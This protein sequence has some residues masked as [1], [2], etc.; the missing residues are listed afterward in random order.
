M[1]T[2]EIIKYFEDKILPSMDEI[3]KEWESNRF[4]AKQE[5]I[6]KGLLTGLFDFIEEVNGT[7][8]AARRY[9]LEEYKRRM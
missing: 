6:M 4:D 3:I 2:K 8:Q 1:E 7:K 9:R 5:R